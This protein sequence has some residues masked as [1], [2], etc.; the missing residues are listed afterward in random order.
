MKNK[1]EVVKVYGLTNRLGKGRFA[2]FGDYDNVSLKSVKAELKYLM[3]EFKVPYGCVLRTRARHYHLILP[4]VFSAREIAGLHQISKSDLA[5]KYYWLRFGRNAL[6][7]TKKS[8]GERNKKLVY[9]LCYSYYSERPIAKKL[10]SY[11]KLAYNIKGVNGARFTL[12][13]HKVEFVIYSLFDGV[14]R[15]YTN[16]FLSSNEFKYWLKGL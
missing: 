1:Q 10:Y 15:A 6:R 5:H 7:I 8:E 14:G 13:P 16:K 3:Q 4:C 9:E 2:Y 11:L 12:V